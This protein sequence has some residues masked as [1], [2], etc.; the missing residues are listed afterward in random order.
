[1]NWP[2]RIAGTGGRP[3]GCLRY[4]LVGALLAGGWQ[5]ATVHF[6]YGGNWTGLFWVSGTRAM[7]PELARGTYTFHGSTG[8][9]GQF[10]RLVAHD[11]WLRRGWWNYQD[12]AVLRYTRILVPGLAW[13][14]AAGQDRFIDAAYIS[15]VLFSIFLG[16][17]WL[18]RWAASHGRSPAWGLA[19]LGVPGTLISIDR[20]TVDVAAI[21][22]CAG[23][24]WYI[25]SGSPGRLWLV[26]ALA[27]LTRDTGLV[28][29]A[30]C[31]AHALRGRRWRQALGYAAAALPTAAWYVF[32]WTHRM[33]TP[34]AH[35]AAVPHW[36]FR[37][38]AVGIFT[39]LFRPA[40]YRFAPLL[41]HAVQV[42]DAVALCGMVLALA[43]AAWDL[44]KG[45][46]SRE[47][48]AMLAFLVVFLAV[49][50]P[51]Y[52][53]NV[54]SYSRPFSPLLLLVAMPA[55]AGGSRWRLAP[56][57]MLDLRIAAQLAPQLWGI[58][59]GIA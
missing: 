41:T 26:S 32:V 48:W 15:I 4:A 9:D 56:L 46:L 29:S 49:S 17:Y 36:L 18:S 23:W 51:N 6:N 43:L 11:P 40:G 27:G 12:S 35:G 47:H 7:P 14:A 37:H 30:A 24:A 33:R 25:R 52:W 20:L 45:P 50:T 21:A 16:I 8:Y 13:L 3:L 31:C 54:Y 38:A 57:A 42:L 39:E 58:L 1:M 59:R 44:R 55:M 5:A 10:Y 28:L 2:R 53:Y 34:A 22:L 19:F